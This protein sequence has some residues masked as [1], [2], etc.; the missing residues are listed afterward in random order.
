MDSS[1]MKSITAE[2][3]ENPESV[4]GFV[5]SYELGFS[6]LEDNAKGTHHMLCSEID[7]KFKSQFMLFTYLHWEMYVSCDNSIL[8][9]NITQ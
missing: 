2:T 4:L 8:S 3:V 9:L 5:R 7:I 1:E 6:R